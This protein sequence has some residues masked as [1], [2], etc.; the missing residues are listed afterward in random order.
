MNRIPASNPQFEGVTAET[1]SADRPTLVLILHT[2]VRGRVR[3]RVEGLYRNRRLRLTLEQ[4]LSA[5]QDIQSVSAS[6]LTGNVIVVHAPALTP[7]LVADLIEHALEHAVIARLPRDGVQDRQAHGTARA[8]IR[9]A[10]DRVLRRDRQTAPWHAMTAA[11]TLKFLQG[12]L[13]GLHPAQAAQRLRRF[14]R[15]AIGRPSARSELAICCSLVLEAPARACARE[16][17]GSDRESVADITDT[18]EFRV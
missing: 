16:S 11:D 3:C 10:L 1:R 15:N 12:R 14:G 9:R 13:E 4:T 18:S 6:E 8:L 2:T 17:A 7:R 5:M